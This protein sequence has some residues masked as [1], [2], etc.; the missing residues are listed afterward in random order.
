MDND[1]RKKLID[2]GVE[3]LADSLLDLALHSDVAGDLIE[4]LLATPKENV[5]RFK[6]KIA[7][8]KRSGHYVDWRGASG[9]AQELE[10]LLQDLRAGVTD[11]LA[12]MELVALFFET[13][14]YVFERCDDSSGNVGDVYRYDAQELFFEYCS[15]CAEKEKIANIILKLNSTDNYGVRDALIDSAGDCLPESAIRMMIMEFQK[16]VDAEKVDYKKCHH[17]RLIESLAKQIKDAKLF[18]KTRIASW[19]ELSGA[20]HVDIA[21]VY[22]ESG[23]VDTAQSWLVRFP[24]G[25]TYRAYERDELLQEIYRRQGDQENVTDLLYKSF[26]SYR[27]TENLKEL[28]DV[29]GDDKRDEVIT[30]EVG[31]ILGNKVLRESDAKFLI[32][33]GMIDK[34]EEYLVAR[35]DQL[36]GDLYDSVLF[37]AEAMASENRNLTASLLYRSLLVSILER[38]YTKAYH[39]GIRYL[40]KLDK[41]SA[42]ITDWKSFNN[43]PEFKD[44]IAK[45]HG[46][47]RSFWSKYGV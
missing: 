34:A 41:L 9:F 17:M 4:R 33:T 5:Q 26:S 28:L 44:Q 1:R 18:E 31:L 45:A 14:E 39:Y 15:R 43:H 10:V 25:E 2:L 30:N 27:S 24:P 13:D 46:R 8:L 19:G 12:G 40:K 3:T 32:A 11:P 22:L 47:K 29:I 7:S 20:A 37:L 42:T 36:N 6:K 35:A 23:D 21:R 16:W 38:G